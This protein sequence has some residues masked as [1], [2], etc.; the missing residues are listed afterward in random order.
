MNSKFIFL[1]SCFCIEIFAFLSWNIQELYTES[2]VYFDVFNNTKLYLCCKI[3]KY[4]FWCLSGNHA[5][6][7][8]IF[9]KP[10]DRY[11]N[12]WVVCVCSSTSQRLTTEITMCLS[13][14][15][16]PLPCFILLSCPLRLL[17]YPGFYRFGY[18]NSSCCSALN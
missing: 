16:I 15:L 4:S 14:C 1:F 2:L 8:L 12:F 9:I 3:E 5:Y 13:F 10:L 6:N 18:V 17:G 11:G 7:L